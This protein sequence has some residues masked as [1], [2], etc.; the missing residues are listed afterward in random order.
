MSNLASKYKGPNPS[1]ARP[2]LNSPLNP[3]HLYNFLTEF[4]FSQNIN[5]VGQE[6]LFDFGDSL[7]Y[8]IQQVT[9][10][11]LSSNEVK[12]KE[13]AEWVRIFLKVFIEHGFIGF[14]MLSG[15][16]KGYQIIKSNE[17]RY[18]IGELITEV[19]DAFLTSLDSVIKENQD[20]I[21]PGEQSKM[22]PKKEII[23]Y[24]CGQ[25]IPSIPDEQLIKFNSKG[26]IMQLC[27]SIIFE[28]PRIFQN[29]V[30]I[31][32]I[33]QDILND[34]NQKWTINSKS[35]KSLQNKTNDFI[36]KELPRISWG[37]S[38]L[39]L[40]VDK[41]EIMNLLNLI[42][43]FAVEVF[44]LWEECP[45]S[46][47]EKEESLDEETK[48][49]TP[50][51]WSI[52]KALLFSITLIFKSI[53]DL[54]LFQPEICEKQERKLIILT[55]SYLYFITSKFALYGFSMHKKVF[56]SV[57]DK[58]LDDEIEANSLIEVCRPLDGNNSPS[59]KSRITY[60][61]LVIEQ[62]MKAINDNMVEQEIL[63]F[64]YPYIKDNKDSLL[65]ESVHLV[66]FAIFFNKKRVSKDLASFYCSL[67]LEGYPNIFTIIQLRTAYSEVIKYTSETDDA[68]C[69][70]CLDKLIKKIE[71]I[72]PESKE[73][74]DYSNKSLK[75]ESTSSN[76][77]DSSKSPSNQNEDD[78]TNNVMLNNNDPESIQAAAL[79]L[80]RGHLL[81]TL[82]DQ[83]Q[84]V[85]LIIIKTLLE[86][87]KEFLE[88]EPNGIGKLA[89]KKVLFDTLSMGLDYTK[90]DV[91][92]KWWL[93]EGS[94]IIVSQ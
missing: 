3:E 67:L 66:I 51:L 6:Y 32:N 69:W 71:N 1:V 12:K 61:L 11:K 49:A 24:I 58:S 73:L 5:N 85:N 9:H 27:S 76:L 84:F 53:V 18:P 35:H 48:K 50:L 10:L 7:F 19:E 91:C 31:K 74:N 80:R 93:S 42:Y 56:F 57:L 46:L 8:T 89:L 44:R 87:I 41:D 21:V 26:I 65:F 37:I 15:L 77:S 86:K 81:L 64:I 52:F 79:Y 62:L 55:Y 36:F 45:L 43:S 47:V 14:I 54:S 75:S 34:N 22:N 72:T 38:K 63:P 94:K 29:G 33:T 25:T 20:I 82:I 59:N 39:V 90:K 16:L 92:V 88:A 83:V 68:L 4:I 40:F 2:L 28:N 30:F 60:Y 13:K 70:L 23:A 78:S 17:K